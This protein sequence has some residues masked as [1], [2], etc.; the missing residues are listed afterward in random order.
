MSLTRFYPRSAVREVSWREFA[1]V[2]RSWLSSCHPLPWR[3]RWKLSQ[4]ME[5]GLY[6]GSQFCRGWG[7]KPMDIDIT[8]ISIVLG[9]WKQERGLYLAEVMIVHNLWDVLQFTAKCCDEKL[10]RHWMKLLNMWCET[11]TWCPISMRLEVPSRHLYMLAD[12]WKYHRRH[13]KFGTTH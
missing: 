6:G 4:K 8:R 5:P 9:S 12:P 7:S 13:I 11:W 10:G 1:S 2:P 3:Q